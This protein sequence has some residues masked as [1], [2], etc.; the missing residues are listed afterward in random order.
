MTIAEI[1][2][3]IDAKRKAQKEELQIRATYDYKL[4]DL[5]GRS[6]ARIHS[7][8]NT[9]PSIATVYPGLFDQD[10]LDKQ[11]QEKKNELSTIRFKQFAQ[12]F[13]SKFKEVGNNQ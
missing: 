6:I 4:A 7:S 13:N 11:I 1:N 2:R 12:A 3:Y 5:I 9:M 8:S 10:E